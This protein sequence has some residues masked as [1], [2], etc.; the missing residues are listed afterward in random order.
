MNFL[1][2]FTQEGCEEPDILLRNSSA[3]ALYS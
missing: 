3:T 1:V 2:S